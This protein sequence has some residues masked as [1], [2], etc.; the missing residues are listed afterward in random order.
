MKIKMQKSN[1]KNM[2]AAYRRND[3]NFLLCHFVF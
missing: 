2:V 3:F 1:I